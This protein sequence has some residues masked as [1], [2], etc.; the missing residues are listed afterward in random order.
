MKGM[1]LGS[2]S[3]CSLSPSEHLCIE[4]LTV[5]ERHGVVALQVG[6]VSKYSDDGGIED[7]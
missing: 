2:I 7:E 4:V 3:H 1:H 6:I 5:L